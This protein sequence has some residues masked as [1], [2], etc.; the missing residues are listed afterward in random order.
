MAHPTE[1]EYEFV[2]ENEMRG[3]VY[4]ISNKGMPDLIKIGYTNRD[5]N[6]RATELDSTSSPYPY[7]VDYEILLDN[8][9]NVEQRVFQILHE[10]R[11]NPRKEW[12]RCNHETAII[13]IREAAGN[14]TIYLENFKKLER[15]Q[16]ERTLLERKRKL[17]EE[18]RR[19][20]EERI[21]QQHQNAEKMRQ[22]DLI[23][24]KRTAEQNA[25]KAI[26][27]IEKNSM[28]DK[29]KRI[30]AMSLGILC[31]LLL[32]SPFI[33]FFYEKNKHD[34]NAM[35]F[36]GFVFIIALTSIWFYLSYKIDVLVY[37]N[38]IYAIKEINNHLEKYI[39]NL[40]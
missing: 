1:I 32:S 33:I 19:L 16:F 21:L 12:F 31:I 36:F 9:F 26:M 27:Q 24:K 17:E 23:N 30:I 35:L 15:E 22:Q 39:K 40:K 4:I 37:N 20:E 14:Q 10:F 3:W 5:P 18:Q 38:K 7:I 34:F 11:I 2:G 6:I 8:A 28:S 25:K 13:A 29:N